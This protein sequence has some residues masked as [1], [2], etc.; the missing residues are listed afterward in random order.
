[1]RQTGAPIA[2]NQAA[3]PLQLGYA[4]ESPSRL[5]QANITAA[6]PRVTRRHRGKEALGQLLRRGR[7][8]RR[9][10]GWLL[11]SSGR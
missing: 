2:I 9:R 10:A 11:R 4:R 8:S 1:M 3:R 6:H 7:E 5:Q